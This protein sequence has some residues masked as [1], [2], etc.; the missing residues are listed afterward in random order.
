[1][2]AA[3][4]SPCRSDQ[5]SDGGSD[6]AMLAMVTSRAST[7]S[8]SSPKLSASAS[9]RDLLS[10]NGVGNASDRRI[11]AWFLYSPTLEICAASDTG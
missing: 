11:A 5:P 10:G 9:N 8:A 4:S 2:S 1:M 7:R 3:P 6:Q